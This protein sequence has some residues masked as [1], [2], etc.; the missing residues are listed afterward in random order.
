MIKTSIYS[1]KMED[2]CNL[3]DH[4]NNFKELLSK[5][6]NG[7]KNI[8]DEEHIPFVD[9]TIQ[10]SQITGAINIHKEERTMCR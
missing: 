1:L 3:F 9:S 7:E 2:E 8:K 10:I 5:I 6:I 4:I